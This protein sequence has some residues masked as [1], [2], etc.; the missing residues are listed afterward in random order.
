MSRRF[1]IMLFILLALLQV[2]INR[3]MNDWS[4]KLDLLY[5][6]LAYTAVKSGY[7]KTLFA[8]TAIGLVTDYFSMNI[9]GVFGF[10]R[11]LAAFLLHETAPHIDLKNNLIVFLMISL[12]LCL[13]NGSAN[14]FFYFIKNTPFNESMI[15]YQP[16]LT[17][18]V[19][20]AIFNF[21]KARK[22]LDVY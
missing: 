13:S 12:S 19:G 18:L 21:A 22:Y 14:V 2:I 5:L 9:L 1:G 11:T 6:V 10:S 16:I 4:L 3:Y 17:G 7:F 20:I 8:G 15:L